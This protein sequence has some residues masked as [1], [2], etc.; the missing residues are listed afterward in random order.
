MPSA[1]QHV[2]RIF[3]LAQRTVDVGKCDRGEEPKRVGWFLTRAAAYSL[4]RRAV[5]SAACTSPNH[6]PGVDIDSTATA[7]PF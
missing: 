5:S 4:L 7:T 3:D 2:E 1:P 6:T